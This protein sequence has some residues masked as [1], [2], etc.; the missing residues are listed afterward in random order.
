[1]SGYCIYELYQLPEIPNL[2]E[3]ESKTKINLK[4]K[5]KTILV[6]MPEQENDYTEL[7][8]ATFL[9]EY[10]GNYYNKIFQ[11][12]FIGPQVLRK[13]NYLQFIQKKFYDDPSNFLTCIIFNIFFQNYL[14]T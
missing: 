3:L 14:I 8:N 9:F 5:Q 13:Q 4:K 10:K 7:K 1:M 12:I 2:A 6:F 11:T